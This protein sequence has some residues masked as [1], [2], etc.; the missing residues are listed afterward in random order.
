MLEAAGREVRLL[1]A[2]DLDPVVEARVAEH[3]IDERVAVAQEAIE[4]AEVRLEATR[5]EH[6]G[7]LALQRGE[8]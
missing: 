1:D 5:E 6:R 2:R 8:I 4:A 3:V 7:F